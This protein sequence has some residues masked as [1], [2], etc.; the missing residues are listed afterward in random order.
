M[1]KAFFKFD[2][3]S[4]D[5]G[6]REIRGFATTAQVD[7]M[8]D[9]VEPLGC[10][11]AKSVPLLWQHDAK[12][13]VGRVSFGKPTAKG[14]PFLARIPKIDI[15]GKLKEMTDL[16]WHAVRAGL[17][18][19]VSIGFRILSN[20]VEQLASGGLR[21]LSCEILE[22]SL[23]S[24]PANAE[25][26]ILEVR[27][28]AA[29]RAAG[30]SGK[31]AGT[32]QKAKLRFDRIVREVEGQARRKRLGI[33]EPSRVVR[34]SNADLAAGAAKVRS[35]KGAVELS[36]AQRRDRGLGVRADGAG[37]APHRVVKL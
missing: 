27:A 11:F 2:L 3:K 22:L 28:A 15:P 34:L 14:V 6:E 4:L 31:R 9:I 8:G 36:A 5:E 12:I 20:A 24:I 30:G 32:D 37:R 10:V 35:A 7:R 16:A 19:T 29:R 1:Q 21:I 17:V 26:E 23:V 33:T 13:P 18:D 25:A